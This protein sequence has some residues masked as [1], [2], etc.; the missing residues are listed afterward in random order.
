MSL[1]FGLAMIAGHKYDET[2]IMVVGII[3]L[4]LFVL[5]IDMTISLLPI[6]L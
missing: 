1:W 3:G 5:G 6:L 2:A 4:W